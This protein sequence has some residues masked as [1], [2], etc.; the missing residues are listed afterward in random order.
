M[1]PINHVLDYMTSYNS[2]TNFIIGLLHSDIC[3][4]LPDIAKNNQNQMQEWSNT[5]NTDEFYQNIINDLL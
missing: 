3:D 5:L 4:V 2:Q 1:H